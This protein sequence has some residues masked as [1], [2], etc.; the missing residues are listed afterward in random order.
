MAK[1]NFLDDTFEKLAELGLSTAKKTGQAVNKTFNP[2]KAL[3]KS[4]NDLRNK[5]AEKVAQEQAK[6]TGHTPLDFDR[7]EERYQ[8]QD[9]KKEAD[10]RNRLFQLIKGEEKELIERRKQEKQ[11]QEQQLL[12]EKEERRKKEEE[13]RMWEDSDVPQGKER[14]SILAPKKR[15]QK[16]H[17]EFKPSTGKS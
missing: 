12:Q 17:A 15:V 4:N 13:K 14:K 6:K 16:E 3:E 5:E 11:Q 1:S 8:D 7:L 9:K 10:L 2:L